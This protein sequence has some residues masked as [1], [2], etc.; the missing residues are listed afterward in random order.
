MAGIQVA[1]LVLFWVRCQYLLTSSVTCITGHSDYSI[2]ECR[3][4][5]F[6]APVSYSEGSEFESWT[7]SLL[8]A[9]FLFCVFPRF[10]QASAVALQHAIFSHL[11]IRR[12]MTF[13]ICQVN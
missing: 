11:D 7:G 3:W 12:L 9:S 13:M 5:F 2:T 4:A 1:L 10:F 8:L 6:I